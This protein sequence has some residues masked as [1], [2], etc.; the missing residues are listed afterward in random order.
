MTSCSLLS[1]QDEKLIHILISNQHLPGLISQ[2]FF[3]FVRDILRVLWYAP[4]TNFTFSLSI[5]SLISAEA[6]RIR[7]LT[8]YLFT[9]QNP[10]ASNSTVKYG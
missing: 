4:A 8:L 2:H 5:G 10:G 3:V 7:L 1:V 9:G 6:S